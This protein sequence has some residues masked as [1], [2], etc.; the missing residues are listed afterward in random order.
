MLMMVIFANY[1]ISGTDVIRH[2]WVRL[3]AG[4]SD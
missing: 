2:A 1:V 3:S 4:E